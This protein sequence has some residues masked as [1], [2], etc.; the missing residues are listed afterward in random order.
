MSAGSELDLVCGF[1]LGRR[2]DLRGFL[3]TG[4]LENSTWRTDIDS[5]GRL[6]STAIGSEGHCHRVSSIASDSVVYIP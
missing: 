3:H 6:V 4:L 2:R 5:T 1:L